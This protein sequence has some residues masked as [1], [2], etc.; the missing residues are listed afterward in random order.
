MSTN[1]LKIEITSSGLLNSKK[2]FYKVAG[3]SIPLGTL[4]MYTTFCKNFSSDEGKYF[5]TEDGKKLLT[6]LLANPGGQ[7]FNLEDHQ[8][9][10]QV[11]QQKIMESFN[12]I[13]QYLIHIK[14]LHNFKKIFSKYNTLVN[15]TLK[16][17]QNVIIKDIFESLKE[18]FKDDNIVVKEYTQSKCGSI[19]KAK[20]SIKSAADFSGKK[21]DLCLS[22]VD[23]VAFN[24]VRKF[25]TKYIGEA[26]EAVKEKK[27][28]NIKM[29]N[30]MMLI[31]SYLKKEITERIN[32]YTKKNKDSFPKISKNPKDI[33]NF[34]FLLMKS[35]T[36]E[37]QISQFQA[38]SQIQSISE[39]ELITK[40]KSIFQ[41]DCISLLNNMFTVVKALG[42]YDSSL[43][44]F[45]NK[46]DD[47]SNIF[48]TDCYFEINDSEY[49]EDGFYIGGS[50]TNKSILTKV[51]TEK[52]Q[53]RFEIVKKAKESEKIT[54]DLEVL[55]VSKKVS[56]Y[57]ID[58][59]LVKDLIDFFNS[60]PSSCPDIHKASDLLKALLDGNFEN[61][62]SGLVLDWWQNSFMTYLQEG[63]S[64]VLVGDTSGGKTF[65]S[66]LGMQH[67]FNKYTHDPDAKFIYLAPTSQLA[68]LQYS[69]IL[70][71]NESNSDK[72]GI[73]YKSIVDI[74][75]TARVIIGTPIDVRRYL[76]QPMFSKNENITEDNIPEKIPQAIAQSFVMNC[77]VIFIDE[78]QTLSP[79]YVQ[80]QE[81]EQLME[82]KAIEEVLQTINIKSHPDSQVVCISAT[83]S[84][85]SIDNLKAK[86]SS[87]TGIHQIETIKYTSEDIGLTHLK[88][89]DTFEPIMKSVKILPIK[90]Q[91]KS[92][93]EITE[94]INEQ[95]LTNETLEMIIRDAYEKRNVLPISFYRESELA[96]IQMYK[97]FISY[98]EEKNRACIQ[99]FLL[100]SDYDA[101]VE[102]IKFESLTS[103]DK[104][105]RWLK[106][107]SDKIDEIK[108]Q[109]NIDQI[110]YEPSKTF[111][112][113]F[114]F[115]NKTI[116]LIFTQKDVLDENTIL[117]AEL[118][119][120][121][122]EFNLI[123]IKEMAFQGVI[124]PYYRFT[125]VSNSNT[126]LMQDSET[127]ADSMLKT[128]LMAQNADPSSN[129]SSITPFILRGLAF[130]VSVI[131]SSI[132][133]GFQLEIFKFIN[134]KSRGSESAIPILFSEYGMSMGINT[135]LMS[136]CI[137]RKECQEIGASEFKQIIGRPGR[138]GNKSLSVPIAYTFNISNVLTLNRLETL[139]F[140]LSGITSNFFTDREIYD[141]LSRLMIKYELNK[142]IVV[143]MDEVSSEKIM[144]GDSF[145]DIGGD[146][147]LLVR[148]N[149]LAKLQVA[150]IYH[151]CK[152]LFPNIAESVLKK[153]YLFLQKAE[154]YNLNVQIS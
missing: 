56:S 90:I 7:L 148:K 34:L 102:N 3:K 91:G 111:L 28:N 93:D 119:G 64:F 132:P 54:I 42:K 30:E 113:L 82:C 78:V 136:V 35:S 73:C 59:R 8:R 75:P 112:E 57:N 84:D 61:L 55:K 131:T 147:I 12:I 134:I 144:I 118:Y 145:K 70:A 45:F 79:T 98:L 143:T 10:P 114:A 69:N 72:F 68:L 139:D 126:F 38:I 44:A 53:K 23:Q 138:R 15:G 146:S 58:I 104:R 13:K 116:K 95:K 49:K 60:I 152:N 97:D 107:I 46:I 31:L 77:R 11:Y 22:G 20:T 48:E 141:Y 24:T 96:T 124:H 36:K 87:I 4:D 26:V 43:D 88:D 85:E 71:Q 76:I 32:T 19:D 135:S 39:M 108:N 154:F 127:G 105:T 128:I 106:I 122:Y 140:N 120:L 47:L 149:Q 16:T 65:I 40:I 133:V 150:E 52:T 6:D 33:N 117:S 51:Y 94:N 27:G 125:K 80:T 37:D 41:N 83:L 50:N 81:V 129:T 121:L 18:V 9:E 67:I 25:C 14:P 74:P 29:K 100:K 5:K 2:F 62:K 137:L 17:Y 63:K 66:L 89:K 99:W 130:G 151:V 86:I 101:Q 153:L 109:V 110:V 21:S 103:T 142:G 115:Y 92:I 123:T 1:N